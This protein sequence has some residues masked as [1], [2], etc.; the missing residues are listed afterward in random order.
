MTVRL[1][2]PSA[3]TRSV[4]GTCETMLASSLFAFQTVSIWQQAQ[5]TWQWQ[6]RLDEYLHSM[7]AHC[8]ASMQ[9][10]VQMHLCLSRVGSAQY[11]LYSRLIQ[12]SPCHGICAGFANA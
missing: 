7:R 12:Q 9:I 3:C 2:R 4:G 8:M 1:R 5:Q 11:M 6:E 10:A